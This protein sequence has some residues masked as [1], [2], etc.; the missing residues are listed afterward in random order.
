MILGRD[1]EGFFGG[2]GFEPHPR[3]G[4]IDIVAGVASCD[5]NGIQDDKFYA[6]SF[7]RDGARLYLSQ[8][9]DVDT[10]FGLA[11]GSS[12]MVNNKSCAVLKADHSRIIARESVKIIAGKGIIDSK[13]GERNSLG[14]LIQGH[15]TIDLIAGN[16]DSVLQPLVKGDNLVAQQKAL[17]NE[18]GKLCTRVFENQLMIA[19]ISSYLITHVHGPAG[20]PSPVLIPTLTQEGI[21]NFAKI[22]TC[23]S[24]RMNLGVMEKLTFLRPAS[25]KYICSKLVKTT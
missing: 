16:E 22:T 20:T 21:D 24:I 9:S 15:G 13:D 19:R 23:T 4:A 14:G 2:K 11:K 18:V 12:N 5:K 6:P 7:F 10:Y 17:L 8:R 1:R 3:S 25:D